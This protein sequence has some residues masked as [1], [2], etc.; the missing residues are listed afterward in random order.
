[1]FAVGCKNNRKFDQEL[2][3]LTFSF[4]MGEVQRNEG[5]RKVSDCDFMV[6]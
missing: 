4:L 3:V 5:E 1:M 2:K 6:S